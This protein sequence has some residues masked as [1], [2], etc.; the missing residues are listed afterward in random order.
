MMNVA[1]NTTHT[2]VV[3]K[4]LTA[5]VVA[6]ELPNCQD[7]DKAVCFRITLDSKLNKIQGIAF[8]FQHTVLHGIVLDSQGKLLGTPGVP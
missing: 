1:Q 5:K 6:A 4:C 2:L 7:E 3:E 8:E